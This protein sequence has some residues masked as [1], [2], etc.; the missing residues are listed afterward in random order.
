MKLKYT[1]FIRNTQYL[2]LVTFIVR[3]TT[4]TTE[5]RFNFY[6]QNTSVFFLLQFLNYDSK[7]TPPT[8]PYTL[9]GSMK[10]NNV[11]NY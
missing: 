6:E 10:C 11:C 2:N 3:G 5:A 4:A 7:I 8:D 9:T 1:H